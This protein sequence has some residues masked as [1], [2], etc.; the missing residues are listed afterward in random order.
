MKTYQVIIDSNY[1]ILIEAEE[2]RTRSNGTI[3]F[4]DNENG[5][6]ER[7]IATFSLNKIIGFTTLSDNTK[8]KANKG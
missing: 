5:F 4:L 6:I 7:V 3:E 2:Y 8:L 1:S